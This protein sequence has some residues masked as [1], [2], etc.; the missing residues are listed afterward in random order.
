VQHGTLL[1]EKRTEFVRELSPLAIDAYQSIAGNETFALRYIADVETPSDFAKILS[2]SRSTDIR[3][4]LTTRGPH[5]DDIEFFIDDQPARS[6]ASQGQ[7]KSAALALKLAELEWV[8]ERV[9]EYPVLMLD[10]VLAELDPERSAHLFK[11]IP[12]DVQCLITTTQPDMNSVF[13]DRAVQ[14]FR[15]DSGIIVPSA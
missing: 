4:K 10:E 8:R 14:M 7:Q 1:I 12:H 5:R 13:G 9:G 11:A 6:K 2:D 15:I 3:R